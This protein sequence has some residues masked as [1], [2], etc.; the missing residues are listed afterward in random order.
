MAYVISVVTVIF[1][2][3]GQKLPQ[4]IWNEWTWLCPH[5]TLFTKQEVAGY[6]SGLKLPIL[7][8]VDLS[9][10]PAKCIHLSVDGHLGSS[11]F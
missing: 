10:N 9:G 6:D 1:A 5:K 7:C 8:M 11:Q 2:V 4:T 3:V